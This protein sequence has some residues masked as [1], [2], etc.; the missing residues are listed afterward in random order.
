MYGTKDV[1]ARNFLLG[2]IQY[3]N[4]KIAYKIIKRREYFSKIFLPLNAVFPY[5]LQQEVER[6]YNVIGLG[7]R[8]INVAKEIL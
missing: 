4:I 6:T 8:V 3:K 7:V 1:G 5:Q 2:Y